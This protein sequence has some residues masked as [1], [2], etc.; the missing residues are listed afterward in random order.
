MAER[1][2]DLVRLAREPEQETTAPIDVKLRSVALA[3]MA[4]A[5]AIALLY[6]ARQVFIPIVLSV[7]ISYALE[8]IVATLIRVRLPRVVAAALVVALFTG[9]VLYTGYALSDDAVALVA[10]VPEAATKL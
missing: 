5:A 2:H 4:S 9:G 7:L 3:V 6:W 1:V 10:A 8:P